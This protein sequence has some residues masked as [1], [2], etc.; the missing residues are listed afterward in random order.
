M[1]TIA[2]SILKELP[3]WFMVAS[4]YIVGLIAAVRL[5]RLVRLLRELGGAENPRRHYADVL[6]YRLEVCWQWFELTASQRAGMMNGV[7]AASWPQALR[8]AIDDIS[9][10]RAPS[11]PHDVGFNV[12]RTWDGQRLEDCRFFRNCIRV[13]IVDEGGFIKLGMHMLAPAGCKRI[14]RR[15]LLARTLYGILRAG[16]SKAFD[17]ADKVKF[18]V[19]MDDEARTVIVNKMGAKGYTQSIDVDTLSETAAVCRSALEIAKRQGLDTDWG[20]FRRRLEPVLAQHRAILRVKGS[21][22]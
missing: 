1:Q 6:G 3:H 10:Y 15:I 9:Q 20:V 18:A 7:G 4:P 2:L 16:G 5:W 14:V 21:E 8:D 13:V 19:V 17:A 22:A 12:K 11:M